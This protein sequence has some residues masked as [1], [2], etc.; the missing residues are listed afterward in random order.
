MADTASNTLPQLVVLGTD[1]LSS[2]LMITSTSTFPWGKRS[3]LD[4]NQSSISATP[5]SVPAAI[6]NGYRV[7]KSPP[8]IGWPWRCPKRRKPS[9]LQYKISP[10]HASP[11]EPK[12]YP[13]QAIPTI[14]RMPCSPIREA[15]CAWW[16]WT[17]T[18]G[19][20]NSFPSLWA[21]LVVLNFGCRSHAT[22]STWLFVNLARC[23]MVSLKNSKV[24][25]FSTS[26][27]CWERKALFCSSRQEVTF[28]SAPT[29]KTQQLTEFFKRMGSGA[30]PLD[31]RIMLGF[32]P[33]RRTTESSH[34]WTMVLSWRRKKS[35]TSPS[36][37]TASRFSVMIGSLGGFA[38]V[39]TKA[40]SSTSSNNKMCKPVY[41][42]IT[43]TLCRPGEI[44]SER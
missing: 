12:P 8:T 11:S 24:S 5:W 43:P 9:W 42:S 29:P 37:F 44:K 38:L 21:N 26:P 19:H 31:R 20:L 7:A 10:P 22:T 35:T 2:C 36:L 30:Y 3:L 41:G 4:N 14:S 34:R 15:M 1:R 17:G 39:I 40:G 33:W 25:S 27:T 32:L 6:R 28:S 16:C 18:T 23:P 13:S